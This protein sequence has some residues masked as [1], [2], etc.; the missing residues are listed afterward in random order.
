MI[1]FKP[2]GRGK[3]QCPAD[4]AYPNGIAL[5]CRTDDARPSCRFPLGY[6]APECGHWIVCCDTCG[7]KIVATA[8]GRPD[9]PTS[10]R[11][12]CKGGAHAGL[13]RLPEVVPG[14]E[15]IPIKAAGEGGD[16]GVPATGEDSGR[17]AAL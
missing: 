6:P 17:T 15:A 16:Q 5:D 8:A 14:E 9:D 10:V 12:N 13:P 11:V 1:E 7:V 3:A 4:P 2:S